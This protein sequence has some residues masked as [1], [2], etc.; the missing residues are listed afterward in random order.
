MKNESES[1]DGELVLCTSSPSKWIQQNGLIL[2]VHFKTVHKWYEP[3]KNGDVF[4]H[5]QYE[6][7]DVFNHKQYEQELLREFTPDHPSPIGL[8]GNGKVAEF[9]RI[10]IPLVRRMYPSLLLNIDIGPVHM[11][12]QREKVN[13]KQEGF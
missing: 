7:G 1:L 12:K 10:T 5:K 13:W 6:N 3:N 11:P 8:D 4:N 9:R 2:P